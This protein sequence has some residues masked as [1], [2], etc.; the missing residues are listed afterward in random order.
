MS[1]LPLASDRTDRIQID[2]SLDDLYN[3]LAGREG[4]APGTARDVEAAPFSTKKDVFIFAACLGHQL[5]Q[6]T[7]LPDGKKVTIRRDV[8]KPDDVAV[9]QALAL[10]DTGDVRVLERFEDVLTVAEEFAQTGIR[11]L[12]QTLVSQGGKALWNLVDLVQDAT[13]ESGRGV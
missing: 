8:L 7:P 1:A 9:L 12:H 3:E 6:R 10:A 2:A 13:R 11:E 5:G 4:D